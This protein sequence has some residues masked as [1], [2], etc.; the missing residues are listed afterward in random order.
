MADLIGEIGEA[1]GDLW[2]TLEENRGPLTVSQLK[3]RTELPDWQVYAAVGWLAREGKVSLDG[4]SRR[5][6]VTLR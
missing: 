6:V 1:A 3:S 2:R 5:M 4:T